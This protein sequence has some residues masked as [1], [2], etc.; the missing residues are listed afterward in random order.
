MI[1]FYRQSEKEGLN[2]F[3]L[4]TQRLIKISNWK[5]G[6][7]ISG[8]VFH[9]LCML[10]SAKYYFCKGFSFNKGNSTSHV[11]FIHES[12]CVFSLAPHCLFLRVG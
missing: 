3:P 6:F 11:T 2:G 7:L 12:L 1:P 5:P 8:L 4:V 9:I 10:P